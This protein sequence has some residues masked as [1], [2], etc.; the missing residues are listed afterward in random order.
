MSNHDRQGDVLMIRRDDIDI[1]S[2]RKDGKLESKNNCV[3]AEGEAT[4]HAHRLQVQPKGKAEVAMFMM[5]DIRLLHIPKELGSQKVTHE[6][7]GP[8]TLEP[9]C[10]EIRQ[11]REYRGGQVR[12]VLD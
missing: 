11:Q 8:V 6:E 5:N 1:S 7:H 12:R 4:G 10:Y 2:L 3:L 9:G